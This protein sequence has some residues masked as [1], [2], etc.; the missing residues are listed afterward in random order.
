MVAPAQIV[1]AKV[2]KAEVFGNALRNHCMFF[3]ELHKK[4]TGEFRLSD[5]KKFRIAPSRPLK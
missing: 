1:I 2:V 5:N 3:R 4:D